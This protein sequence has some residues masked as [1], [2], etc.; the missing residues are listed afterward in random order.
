[1]NVENNPKEELRR[2]SH[3]TQS[4]IPSIMKCQVCLRYAFN[5]DDQIILCNFCKGAV[6]QKC[7]GA[8]IESNIPEGF[9]KFISYIYPLFL[10]QGEW[11]C[12]KCEQYAH[13]KTIQCCF[14][15][16]K[17]GI[18]KNYTIKLRQKNRHNIKTININAH[19]FCINW[20]PVC[21]K[22]R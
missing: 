9:H 5:P 7:Y 12:Y 6:H 13:N 8:P 18:I 17:L 20:F 22:N 2:K 4:D 14:C 11:F 3:V 21:F 1:M 19:I 15:P 16:Q 10:F